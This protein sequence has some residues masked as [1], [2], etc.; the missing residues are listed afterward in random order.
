MNNNTKI[1][2]NTIV[3]YFRMFLL[4]FLSL[5]TSRITLSALG[6]SDFGVYNVVASIVVLFLFLN[7]ALTSGTQRFLN[8]YLGKNDLEKLKHIFSQS[9]LIYLLLSGII[10]LISETVGIVILEK[11]MNIPDE[12]MTAARVIYQFSVVSTVFMILRI[13]FNAVIIAY[14]KMTFFAYLSI[15]EGILKLIIAFLLKHLLCDRLILY[16]ICILILSLLLFLIYF[17]YCK[18]TFRIIN[19]RKYSDSTLLKEM[20]SFSGWNI[21]GSFASICC[22]QGITILI[23]RFFGVLL[24]A[25]L[26]IANS[27]SNAIL[28]FLS[29][30]QLAFNPQIVKSYAEG[31]L[32]YIYSLSIRTSKLSFY[33]MY[34]IILPF[35]INIS[36][37]LSIWLE[38]VPDMTEKFV[39]FFC[40]QIL[41]EA[42]AGPLWMLAEAEGNIRRYQIVG[43][44]SGI[45]VIPISYILYLLGLSP[46]IALLVRVMQSVFFLFWRLAYLKKRIGFPVKNYII[47][48]LGKLFIILPI[49]YF[50]TSYIHNLFKNIYTKFFCSCIFSCIILFILYWLVGIN[51]QERVYIFNFLKKKLEHINEYKKNTDY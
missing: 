39:L 38:K 3:L 28:G 40:I 19:F 15:F 20:I 32:E 51:K 22:N 48:V 5:Y 45:L 9:F 12:R 13:P 25:A 21:V 14:E 27:I 30:F 42:L 18:K 4:L 7:N 34:F 44:I 17:S 6:E 2:R 11:Y 31:E 49:S 43:G 50:L 23:N 41:I 36:F 24:N 26:G 33:L 46:Y 47:E 8:F 1:L 10:I 29:N 35:W 16:G 37:V